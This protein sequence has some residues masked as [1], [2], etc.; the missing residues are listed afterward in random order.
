MKLNLIIIILCFILIIIVS[1]FF[2]NQKYENNGLPH[3]NVCDSL[4]H[5]NKQERIIKEECELGLGLSIIC[6][7][8]MEKDFCK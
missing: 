4:P 3:P 8:H 6:K 5:S 2:S 1:T 7:Q